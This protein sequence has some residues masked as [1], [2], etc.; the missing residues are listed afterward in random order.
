MLNLDIG[1]VY[2]CEENPILFIRKSIP[3]TRHIH[4]EDIKIEFIIIKYQAQEILIL[5]QF[6]KI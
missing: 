6:L 1:H 4:I 3:Y 5:I 2:C